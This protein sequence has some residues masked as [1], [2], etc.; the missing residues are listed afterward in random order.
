MLAAIGYNE[1]YPKTA[2]QKGLRILC[3]DGGG[4]RGITAISSM[5]SIVDAL[6]G[7][8]VCDAF[9]MIAGTSTG[10][11]IAFLV[12]LRR[13]SSK[14][15]RKR[16]DKLIKRIFVKSA[17]S[18]PM[19]LFTTAT[20]DENPFNEVMSS[21]LSDNSMLASRADPRVPLV[22][23]ISSKMSSTPTQLCLFRNYN[24]KRGEM[25]DAFVQDPIEAKLEL[26]LPLKDDI[27]KLSKYVC[28]DDNLHQKSE[29]PSQ[30]SRHPGM[31][32]HRFP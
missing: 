27:Y 28:Y 18:T 15:A 11:I 7:I 29:K 23:A 6:G 25:S 2:G 10:A 30:G 17:L 14:M 31:Y 8:E 32:I 4:T 16:Y 12:G 21:I 20:Y 1:W 9:D 26:E 5:R 24:Y 13:E 3:L 19:L 22:F